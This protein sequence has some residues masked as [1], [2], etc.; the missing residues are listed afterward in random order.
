MEKNSWNQTDFQLH[1]KWQTPYSQKRNRTSGGNLPGWSNREKDLGCIFLSSSRIQGKIPNN[2]NNQQNRCI[3]S[4]NKR[5][6][7]VF[8]WKSYAEREKKRWTV[9]RE[10]QRTLPSAASFN[11]FLNI[12]IMHICRVSCD[13]SMHRYILQKAS[14]YTYLSSPFSISL[15]LKYPKSLLPTFS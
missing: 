8:T 2:N 6:A 13:I 14:V 9:E 15:Q 5:F 12:K 10:K 7:Y 3:F 1:L 4:L 11:F